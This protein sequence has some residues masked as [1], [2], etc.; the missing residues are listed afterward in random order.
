M[1]TKHEARAGTDAGNGGLGG[2]LYEFILLDHALQYAAQGWHVLPCIEQAGAGA[3]KGPYLPHGFKSASADAVKIRQWWRRWPRALIGLCPAPGIVV[4]DLDSAT[5]AGDLVALNGGRLP[6]TLTAITGRGR[7]L[8]YRFDASLGEV[9]QGRLRRPDGHLLHGIDVKPP[10]RGYV[11]APPSLHPTTG[12]PYQWI[13][14]DQQPVALTRG[15]PQLA[16]GIADLPPLLEAALP[17]HVDRAA[18]SHEPRRDWGRL[19]GLVRTVRDARE[20]TRNKA[21]FWAACRMQEH[22]LAGTAPHWRALEEAAL[23]AGLPA[24]EIWA[25]I[26]SAQSLGGAA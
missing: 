23:D 26:R 17:R 9:T 13:G 1:G 25:T 8:Y 14:A 7:H 19:D 12:E 20:G 5:A 15:A 11:I 3:P 18:A 2:R 6:A 22:E 10:G 24:A 4:L 16:A 21:L